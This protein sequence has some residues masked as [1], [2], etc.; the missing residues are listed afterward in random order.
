[1]AKVRLL[2]AYCWDCPNCAAENFARSQAAELSLE[3][4]E[5]IYRHFRHF[6]EDLEP[7]QELPEGWDQFE[8]V[9]FPEKVRCC[10]CHQVFDTEDPRSLACGDDADDE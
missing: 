3:D 7:W 10:K 1:M 2:T 5:A 9:T 4:R 6:H 8:A